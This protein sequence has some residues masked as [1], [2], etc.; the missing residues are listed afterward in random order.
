MLL[1][2]LGYSGFFEFGEIQRDWRL[3]PLEWSLELAGGSRFLAKMKPFLKD[4]FFSY[5]LAR[6]QSELE[7]PALYTMRDGPPPISTPVFP[8]EE[9]PRRRRSDDS[10]WETIPINP[11]ASGVF[12]L[13]VY[14]QSLMVLRVPSFTPRNL[15][16]NYVYEALAASLDQ[17][18][19]VARD[20]NIRRLLVDV[21]DNGGGKVNLP[22]LLSRALQ[23]PGVFQN[24]SQI[25]S[26][27]INSQAPPVSKWLETVGQGISHLFPSPAAM[28]LLDLSNMNQTLTDAFNLFVQRLEGIYSCKQH[29]ERRAPGMLYSLLVFFVCFLC[30]VCSF[31]LSHFLFT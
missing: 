15:D 26:P 1:S 24:A 31:V 14:R 6:L 3:G 9:I 12:E 19:E 22:M 25:C 7:T 10:P 13:R 29:H 23:G 2:S 28:P 27:V 5:N 30:F 16:F 11:N 20:R 18:V 21:M 8:H 17:M 4:A